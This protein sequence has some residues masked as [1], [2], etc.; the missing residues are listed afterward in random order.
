MIRTLCPIP[1]PPPPPPLSTTHQFPVR[2][3]RFGENDFLLAP[4]TRKWHFY[5]WRFACRGDAWMSL[6]NWLPP[7]RHCPRHQLAMPRV[8]RRTLSSFVLQSGIQTNKP[9]GSRQRQKFSWTNDLRSAFTS[10][11]NS[12]PQFQ[13]DLEDFTRKWFNFPHCKLA[14][15]CLKYIKFNV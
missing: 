10:Y 14:F 6:E 9:T 13:R 12:Q 8:G 4:N 3:L 7:L 11:D 2:I 15:A 5:C 1:L